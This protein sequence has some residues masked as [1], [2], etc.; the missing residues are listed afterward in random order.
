MH[1]GGVDGFPE[2]TTVY[3][4]SND[5]YGINKLQISGVGDLDIS[6][7][8]RA[9]QAIQGTDVVFH[10]EDV[11]DSRGG[12]TT[13]A[14]FIVDR[15]DPFLQIISPMVATGIFDWVGIRGHLSHFLGKPSAAITSYTRQR[16]AIA[17]SHKSCG[18]THK[19]GI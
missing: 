17:E 3:S 1:R 8:N 7:L 6:H 13:G 12:M 15:F 18:T 11:W 14:T 9:L 10:H 4:V 16:K 2:V 19:N 5:S